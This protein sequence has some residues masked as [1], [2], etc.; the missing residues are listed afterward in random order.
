MTEAKTNYTNENEEH[1]YM[2]EGRIRLIECN[3][4]NSNGCNIYM[5][6][7]NDG[8]NKNYI[9]L[10]RCIVAAFSVKDAADEL[11]ECMR[12]AKYTH[13]ETP[14]FENETPIILSK[15]SSITIATVIAIEVHVG[16]EIW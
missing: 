8:H 2:D 16:N 6:I 3:D 14:N 12:E 11:N 13:W 1:S 5:Y 9:T 15:S 7:F 10:H 4:C